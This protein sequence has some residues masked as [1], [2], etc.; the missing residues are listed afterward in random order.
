MVVKNEF[1]GGNIGVTGLLTGADVSAALEGMPEHDRY[2][3]PDV[4]LSRGR[5]LDGISAAQL[6]RRVEIVTTDGASLV[7]ALRQ[8]AA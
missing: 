3:L 6:P 5:F 8:E 1:F 4:V 2:L 7:D